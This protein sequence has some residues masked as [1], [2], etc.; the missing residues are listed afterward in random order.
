MLAPPLGAPTALLMS[1]PDHTG[2]H[3]PLLLIFLVLDRVRPRWWLPIL[4]TVMLIWAQV[5]DALVIVEGA[6]PIAAVC[7]LR[8]YRRRG[9]W[10]GQWYDLSLAAGALLSVGVAK[11]VLKVVEQSGGFYVRTPLAA[12]GTPQDVSSL[13]WPKIENVFLVFGSDFFGQVFGRS[14]VVAIIHLV[15]V[16]LVAWALAHVIRRFYVEDDQIVQM[17]AVAFV[18]VLAAY[19]FGTKPDSNEIVG[20]LP[21]GAVLAGRVLGAKVIS[22]RLVPALAVV[23]V[24]CSVLLLHNATSKAHFNPNQRVATWLHRHH[25]NYGLAGFWNASSITLETSGNVKVRPVRTYQDTVVAA[26]FESNSTWYDPSKHYANFLV[27]TNSPSCGDLCLTRR[28]WMSAFG[29]PASIH[30]VGQYW[31]LVYNKNLL[32][33]VQYVAFCGN[34]WSWKATFAP[35]TNLHCN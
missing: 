22:N 32:P 7:A 27:W 9:P 17:L 30:H 29:A 25:L 8:M 18:V 23:F 5:A 15:G 35:T 31:V 34:A 6:L 11:L 2:T 16:V 13:L 12:F 3:V 14:V 33:N 20:L 10:S 4:I 24:A 21:I 28:G 19:I 1:N 26:N